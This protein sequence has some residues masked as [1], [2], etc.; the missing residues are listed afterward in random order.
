MAIDYEQIINNTHI[1]VLKREK[2]SERIC[3]EL[4]ELKFPF[5][6]L[7]DELKMMS[8]NSKTDVFEMERF[9]TY[10]SLSCLLGE[11]DYCV[12]L[13]Q[14]WQEEIRKYVATDY[15]AY[16]AAMNDIYNQFSTLNGAERLNAIENGKKEYS[17]RC[18]SA[19]YY[20][21]MGRKKYY[22]LAQAYEECE[23]DPEILAFSHRRIGYAFPEFK[24]GD[25][26]MIIYKSNFGFGESSYFFTNIRYKSIDLVPF[27]DWIKYRYAETSEIIRYTQR[28]CLDNSYWKSAMD[29]TA[30]AYNHLI[31]RPDTFVEEW[32]IKECRELVAG[33]EGIL[34][35][36]KSSTPTVIWSLNF[37]TMTTMV[38]GFDFIDFKGKK[39]SGAL[40]YIE[41]ISEIKGISDNV[42]GYINRILECNRKVVP[43]LKIEIENLKAEIDQ[44]KSQIKEIE[45]EWTRL[46]QV[47]EE[48]NKIKEEVK[49]AVMLKQPVLCNEE[50]MA[51]VNPI[52]NEKY[53]GFEK[54]EK[55]FATIDGIYN[56]LRNGLYRNENWKRNIEGYVEVIQGY[57][58]KAG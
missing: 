3:V 41:K 11:F 28:H 50:Q 39:I 48:H 57:F 19:F 54:T 34:W 10:G 16:L 51:L 18:R 46:K 22:M 45:P 5:D 37:P 7:M 32:I 24:L 31:T 12:S 42:D 21:M 8:R 6:A 35:K 33:L 29:F 9:V 58:G 4:V 15:D 1:C 40:S 17:D 43:E 20:S 53:P 25:D 49:M 38:T 52:M 55:E 36:G 26:F 44:I 13:D 23:K 56:Q 27:S 14:P 2:N 30:Q 47:V